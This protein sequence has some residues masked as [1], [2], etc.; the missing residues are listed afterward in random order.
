[1]RWDRIHST[2]NEIACS[3]SIE[4]SIGLPFV[5]RGDHFS[6]RRSRPVSNQTR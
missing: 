5:R 1:M 2:T 6:T 4:L 3:A